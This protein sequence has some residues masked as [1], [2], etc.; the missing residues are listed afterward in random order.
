MPLFNVMGCDF[1][2]IIGLYGAL[3]MVAYSLF[4]MIEGKMSNDKGK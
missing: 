2:C 3:W 1:A 4:H